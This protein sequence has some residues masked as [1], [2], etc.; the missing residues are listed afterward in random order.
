MV[1]Q[2]FHVDDGRIVHCLEA[3]HPKPEVVDRHDLHRVK[4]YRVRAVGGA[5]AE[6][7]LLGPGQ[8]VTGMDAKDIPA[9]TIKPGEDDHPIP[10]SQAVE[11]VRL[12]DEPSLRRSLI[13]LLRRRRDVVQ[14]RLNPIG[15]SWKPD[16]SKR[17]QA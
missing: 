2:R 9:G 17:R 13:S 7:S 15:M 5:R 10:R 3:A 12:E 11:D 6:H 1:E 8:V 16:W 14:G 4:P